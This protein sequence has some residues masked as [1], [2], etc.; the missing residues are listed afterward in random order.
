MHGQAEWTMPKNNS[1]IQYEQNACNEKQHPPK[2]GHKAD[3]TH[4][5]RVKNQDALL[6]IGHKVYAK[7]MVKKSTP[8][9]RLATEPTLNTHGKEKYTSPKSGHKSLHETHIVRKG[10]PN[11]RLA[12]KP[13]QTTH[14]K[15]VHLTEH[16]PQ[17]L[18]YA[19][20]GKNKYTSPK[21]GH[22]AYPWH[23]VKNKYT[24]SKTVHKPH[25]VKNKYTLSKTG[26]RAY[27]NHTW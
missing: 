2:A 17:S 13:T 27:T 15:E 16:W 6:K 26:H 7:H 5:H 23:M 4:T 9:K 21:I 8:H 24:S 19:H 18:H 20:M 1:H 25:K 12:T 22:R 11:Q 3:T 10:T 14:S